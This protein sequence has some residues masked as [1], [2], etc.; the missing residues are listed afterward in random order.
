MAPGTEPSPAGS[1]PGWTRRRVL[2]W[3]LGVASAAAGGGWAALTWTE[4][5]KSRARAA[6][7]TQE[8]A[9]FCFASHPDAA[10]RV[11]QALGVSS[12][13]A[14]ALLLR[15]CMDL[16]AGHWDAAR[17]ALSRAPLS[18]TPEARLLLELAN[19]RPGAPD[20]RHAFFDAWRALECPDLEKSPL[21][22][23][24]LEPGILLDSPSRSWD[25]ANEPQRFAL[26]VLH[27]SGKES[28]NLIWLIK[29]V[30]ASTS[31]PLLMGMYLQLLE[32]V[33]EPFFQ[34]EMLSEVKARL[35]ELARPSPRCLQLA[36]FSLL[37][38]KPPT[39]PFQRGDLEALERQ[40]TIPEWK[41]TS[42]ARHFQEM[43]ALFDGLT[44][45]PGHHAWRM[46]F[47]SQGLPLGEML[48]RRVQASRATLSDDDQRW[49]GRLLWEV[50]TRLRQQ[51]SQTELDQGIRLQLIS[52]ELTRYVPNKEEAVNRWVELGIWEKAVRRAGCYRW[53]LPSLQEEFFAARAR[54]EQAWMTAF[55]GVGE[56]P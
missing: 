10:S 17:K 35:R 52:S 41:P 30:R 39:E 43:R 31:V 28:A 20:W 55:T 45:A 13:F 4:H 27:T 37:E 15:A 11:E 51:R 25:A 53:P 29:Q 2:G 12:N 14:P 46:V 19:R 44:Y 8:A 54:D 36:L 5:Q 49:M 18:G 3:T 42:N 47:L 1:K 23:A 22:S 16:E 24:P 26:T 40:L 34:E 38:D 50:G 21:L 56:L 7:L 48:L 33:T 6:A 32:L 9:W